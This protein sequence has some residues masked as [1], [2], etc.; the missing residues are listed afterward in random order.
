MIDD[1]HHLVGAQEI[2]K[3]L[4]VSRQRVNQLTARDDFPA[5]TVILAGGKVWHTEE[6]EEWERKRKERLGPRARLDLRRA[7]RL[8]PCL[9]AGMSE[10]TE[11]AEVEA[12][13]ERLAEIAKD[14]AHIEGISAP[15]ALERLR[16]ALLDN[17]EPRAAV[18]AARGA[19]GGGEE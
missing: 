13:A 1:M 7:R 15:E 17:T 6:V 8:R 12:V 18:V 16:R 5:P 9:E 11:G 10:Q 4:G 19:E 14:I 2:A 3:M